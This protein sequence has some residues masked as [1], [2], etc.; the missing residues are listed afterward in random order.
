MVDAL[1]PFA[2]LLPELEDVD[3]VFQERL[4]HILLT[5]GSKVGGVASEY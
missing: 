2:S 4:A 5:T 3:K 1:L